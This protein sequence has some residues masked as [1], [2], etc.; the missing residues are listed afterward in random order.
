MRVCICLCV[1][2]CLWHV[3][4][5]DLAI[6][7]CFLIDGVFQIILT[8]NDG[9]NWCGSET[10]SNQKTNF[11]CSDGNLELVF[12]DHFYYC[13]LEQ[14]KQGEQGDRAVVMSDK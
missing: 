14:G 4:I 5:V 6:Q 11:P 12:L 7:Q 13:G 2:L 8:T 10:S 9:H 1:R 3:C